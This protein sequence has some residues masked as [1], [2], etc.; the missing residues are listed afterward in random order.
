VKCKYLYIFV[1][2]WYWFFFVINLVK[3]CLCIF[4]FLILIFLPSWW[5]IKMF[6]VTMAVSVAVCEIFSVKQWRHLENQV[7]VVQGHWKWLRSIHHMRLSIDPHCKCSSI[8][9]HFWVI[10]RWIISWP[11][12][13]CYWSLKVIEIGAIQKLR[14]GFLFAF[15]ST[16]GDILYRLRDITSCW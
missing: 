4:I 13:L 3:L 8:L 5:W 10:C 14:Y 6:I 16:Y 2:L 1:I 11:W 7:R 9:Y 15:H 12:N